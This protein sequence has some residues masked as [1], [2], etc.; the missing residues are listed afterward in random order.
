[1]R[2][3]EAREAE[4]VTTEEA[5]RRSGAAGVETNAPSFADD[6]GTADLGVNEPVVLGKRTR[7]E[8]STGDQS[9]E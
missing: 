1:M 8:L 9:D 2:E 7:S 3:D 4:R 6:T 5:R